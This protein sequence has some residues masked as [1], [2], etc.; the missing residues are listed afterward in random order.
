M[1]QWRW[2]VTY[3]E[4]RAP[5]T[6]KTPTNLRLPKC[7][8]GHLTSDIWK[9]SV[10]FIWPSGELTWVPIWWW[11]L[12]FS[13]FLIRWKRRRTYGYQSICY[14]YARTSDIWKWSLTFICQSAELNWVPIWWWLSQFPSL[15]EI[16]YGSPIL[17]MRTV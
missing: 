3:A 5:T 7:M 1:W 10:T 13:Y 16:S 6:M 8:Q 11:M 4:R 15:F 12:S 2:I 9:C 17:F 14:M